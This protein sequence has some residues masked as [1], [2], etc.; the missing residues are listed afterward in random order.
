[1][2]FIVITDDKDNRGVF[3]LKKSKKI[4]KWRGRNK[5]CLDENLIS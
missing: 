2:T 4:I 5:I 3:R 1:M